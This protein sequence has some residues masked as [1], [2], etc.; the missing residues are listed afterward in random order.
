MRVSSRLPALKGRLG[1]DC[2]AGTPGAGKLFL[3]RTLKIQSNSHTLQFL[4]RNFIAAM[5]Q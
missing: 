3:E 5:S 1:N 2:L 4:K